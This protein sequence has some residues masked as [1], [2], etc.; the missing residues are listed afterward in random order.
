MFMPDSICD[1]RFRLVDRLSDAWPDIARFRATTIDDDVPVLLQAVATEQV[2]HATRLRVAD[3]HII[4]SEVADDA[5]LPV[6]GSGVHEGALYQATAHCDGE[7][8]IE[9]IRQR[10]MSVNETVALAAR[11]C[12]ALD[13]AHGSGLV[14]RSVTPYDL[15]LSPRDGARPLGFGCVRAPDLETN[16]RQMLVQRACYASPEEAGLVHTSVDGRS[17]LYSLGVT[18]YQCLTGRLPFPG[19]SVGQV[20]RG[21]LTA[22]P[23]LVRQFCPSVP[24]ALDELIQRLLRKDPEQRYQSARALLVDLELIASHLAR[25][26]SEPEI[27]LGLGDR[28]LTLTQPSFVGRSSELA[29][30]ERQ[31]GAAGVGRGALVLV[32]APSGG[33]KSRLLEELALRATQRGMWLLRGLGSAEGGLPFEALE[34]VAREVARAGQ[35]EPEVAAWLREGLGDHWQTA[36]EILPELR[37]LFEEAPE[38]EVGLAAGARERSLQALT[39]LLASLGTAERPAVVMLDDAQWV[40]AGTLEAVAAWQ[41]HTQRQAGPSHTL[42]LL[43]FRAEEGEAVRALDAEVRLALPPLEDH[44]VD[45]LLASMAGPLPEE[46]TDTVRRLAQ[47]S[48]FLA[49]S[50]LRGFVE[51]GA[52][53]HQRGGWAVDASAWADIRS[54]ADAATMLERR[55]AHLPAETL[56]A[57]EIGAVLGRHFATHEV[58]AL[59]KRERRLVNQTLAEA[60][61]QQLLWA[62]ADATTYTFVHDKLRE[63]VL[64]Q[65]SAEERRRL[66]VAAAVA[67]ESYDPA[68][69]GEIA[70]HFAEGGEL[71]RALPYAIEAAEEA[72][73][74]HALGAA[75]GFY[76]IALRSEDDADEAQRRQIH[77][78]LADAL[79][80]EGAFDEAEQHLEAMRALARSAEQRAEVERQLGKYYHHRGDFARSAEHLERS[81][82]MR[83]VRVPSGPIMSLLWR[84]VA[85]LVQLVHRRVGGLRPVRGAQAVERELTV[86]ADLLRLSYQWLFVRS[87][88]AAKGSAVHAVNRAERCPPSAVLAEGYSLV[89]ML[90]ALTRDVEHAGSYLAGAIEHSRRGNL[91]QEG[92]VHSRLCTTMC[93]RSRWAETIEH[94][95]AAIRIFERAGETFERGSARYHNGVA[96]L[97]LGDLRACLDYSLEHYEDGVANQDPHAFASGLMLWSRASGGKVPAKAFDVPMQGLEGTDMRV[98]WLSVGRGVC[99]YYRGDFEGAVAHFERALQPSDRITEFIIRNTGVRAWFATVLRQAATAL[100]PHESIARRRLLRRARRVARQALVASRGQPSG[101]PRALRELGLLAVYDGKFGVA[102]R[103]FDRSLACARAQGARVE[104]AYTLWVRG[105][106][107]E[108]AQWADATVDLAVGR[109]SLRELEAGFILEIEGDREASGDAERFSLSLADRFATIQ[110]HGRRIAAALSRQALFEAVHDAGQALLRGD[111]AAIAVPEDAEEPGRWR[112]VWGQDA[113]LGPLYETIERA[114]DM[115]RPVIAEPEAP[116]LEEW[117]ARTAMCVP[118]EEHGQC[119]AVLVVQHRGVAGLYGEQEARLGE[120]I[121]TLAGAALDNAAGFAKVQELSKSLEQRVAERTAELA[122]SNAKLQQ[123]LHQLSAAQERLVQVSRE[124]GM[125]EIATGVLHN[126]GNLL[127]SLKTS[128]FIATE[129]LQGSS[130]PM[131]A[132]AAELLDEHRKG[133]AEFLVRDERGRRFPEALRRVAHRL[134]EEREQLMEE[135]AAIKQSS[136]HI[137][138]VIAAQQDYARGSG[139]KEASDLAELVEEALALQ[140][141]RLSQADITVLCEFEEVPPMTLERHK[142]MHIVLNLLSNAIE[143]HADTAQEG[144]ITV[145][146]RGGDGDGDDAQGKVYIDVIDNG[147]GIVRENLKRIFQ[148]G[149]TTKADGH[150]FGLHASALA[151]RELGGA[152]RCMSD[153]PGTGATFTIE[154]PAGFE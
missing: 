57:L 32:E 144:R 99:D 41:A 52:L 11:V 132:R 73:R 14:H 87:P 2:S 61:Q 24:R 135:L 121:A 70:Y 19:D 42:V 113:A 112:T 20:L 6:L 27:T 69:T 116:A 107:G 126:V 38:R 44:E 89:A 54:S 25:G 62:N 47:G 53:R 83:G 150:G 18:L 140:A 115:R 114:A 21:H 82:A 10:P 1:G 84:L 75:I 151:A 104:E 154:L 118:I 119:A 30:L 79:L 56:A 23:P 102:H 59:S 64:A 81:L 123:S 17:D 133:L 49:A 139:L 31:L 143:A 148:Y 138:K 98:M 5:F 109:T 35:S 90:G 58:A 39:R 153:G 96:S 142:L 40:D 7:L 129:R 78:G 94:G 29:R 28:R 127:N 134:T 71:A 8:L 45:A 122:G 111:W 110:E 117:G 137:E 63:T 43:A 101:R 120:Y 105:R 34:A 80:L 74:R 147:H 65:L 9:R 66:H 103:C 124:A 136:E 15:C 4:L 26:E 88:A 76:R 97:R 93:W 50:L 67:F 128:A 16:H 46:V 36:C 22:A 125:A 92:L 106:V 152:L 72:H 55:I 13:I 60:C 95:D 33:G 12:R 149:Y 146:I 51:V 130:A 100:P 141:Q 145:R 91:Y 48:P 37:T 86:A 131:V 108:S 77:L 3:E 68:P 85:V